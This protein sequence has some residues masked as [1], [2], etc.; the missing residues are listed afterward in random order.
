MLTRILQEIPLKPRLGVC[1]RVCRA[2]AAAVAACT[3]DL[4]HEVVDTQQCDSLQ[5]WFSQH[6]QQIQ[7]VHLTAS[8]RG[9]VRPVFELPT[10]ELTQLE[11]M[12]VDGVTLEL[13]T[14]RKTAVSTRS[15]SGNKRRTAGSS[16]LSLPQPAAAAASTGAATTTAAVLPKMQHL[17]IKACNMAVQ[18]LLKLSRLTTLGSL[19]LV[20][21]DL[22]TYDTTHRKRSRK[23]QPDP[24]A[25]LQT[26]LQQLPCLTDLAAGGLSVHQQLDVS[27]ITNLQHLQRLAVDSSCCPDRLVPVLPTA[28]TA[29]ELTG[30]DIVAPD[31][32]QALS[33]LSS[34][35]EL[36]LASVWLDPLVGLV[37]FGAGPKRGWSLVWRCLC[38]L[39]VTC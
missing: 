26:I 11:H 24:A 29:L 22:L 34:L 32:L 23:K 12:C 1:A 20:A 5:R 25:A 35:Q 4:E 10:A 39:C 28:L 36:Y 14:D 6:G 3:A 8:F 33:R 38:Q 13:H 15:S 31:H 2:W 7:V 18:H 21:V 16:F 9:G 27:S 17:G 19:H 30:I 37:W